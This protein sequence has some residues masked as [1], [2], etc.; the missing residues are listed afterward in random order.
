M[1]FFLWASLPWTSV[2][3]LLLPHT[4]NVSTR[5]FSSWSILSVRTSKHCSWACVSISFK[6]HGNI[7]FAVILFGHE[8]PEHEPD[9]I[10]SEEGLCGQPAGQ[11]SP[12]AGQEHFALLGWDPARAGTAGHDRW[13][14][15]KPQDGKPNIWC[16]ATVAYRRCDPT[17][18]VTRLLLPLL[19]RCA[20]CHSVGE[21]DLMAKG[22]LWL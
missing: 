7:S 16:P 20:Q 6:S 12:A 19:R 4:H 10:D 11:W 17:E 13:G 14:F 21:P 18:F 9:A 1:T 22:G 8:P 2:V 15:Q 5:S 3:V